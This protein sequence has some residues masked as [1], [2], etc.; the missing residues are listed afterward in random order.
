MAPDHYLK[1][2]EKEMIFSLCDSMLF[3]AVNYMKQFCML[4]A[5]NV[6]WSG[7]H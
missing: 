1:R 7:D 4:L 3:T 2:K 5:S 6:P